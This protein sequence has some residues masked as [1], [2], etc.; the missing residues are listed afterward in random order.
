MIETPDIAALG[1]LADCW[2]LTG[3]TASGKSQ[4]GL[5]LAQRL[6]AEILSL[7]SMAVYRGMD[8]GTAKPG[9]AARAQCPHH[10]IDLVDPDQDFSLSQYVD[11]AHAAA[12]DVQQRGRIPLFVGGTPLYLKALLRGVYQGPAADWDF[13]RQAEREAARLGPEA[14]HR[15]LAAVDPLSADHLHPRD[16]RRIIRALEVFHLT[17]Q[18]ISHQ[19]LQ[20]D[21]GR[22]AEACR[23]FVLG[24]ERP[25]LH[26]RIDA[27]VESMFQAGLLNEVQLLLGRYG[28]LGRTARQAV[29][30]REASEHLAGQRS[31]S[32]TVEAVKSRTRQFARRQETWFRQLS[33]CRRVPMSADRSPAETAEIIR[34]MASLRA[35]RGGD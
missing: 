15:Q 23:V 3:P 16:Q 13:R 17:G 4:V 26:L 20:F 35:K 21:E 10:L 1:P 22:P 33:E 5:E 19:Q 31:L 6:N 2:F 24:W 32:E 28:V 14:L 25:Q 34:Q 27:R 7:D 30:Y 8:I 18:P 29:G 12:Q 11:A 9:A